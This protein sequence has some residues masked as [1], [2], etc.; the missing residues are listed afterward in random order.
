MLANMRRLDSPVWRPS[1]VLRKAAVKGNLCAA[2]A[3]RNDPIFRLPILRE[4]L[5]QPAVVTGP[6]VAKVD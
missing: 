2:K 4:L 5:L 6:R 1:A 3:Q